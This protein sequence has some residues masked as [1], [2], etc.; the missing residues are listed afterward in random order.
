MKRFLTM[1]CLLLLMLLSGCKQAPEQC[2][3]KPVLYLYPETKTEVSVKLSYEG[4]LTCTY[5]AYQGGWKVAAF[6]NGRILDGNGRE[7]NYLYWEGKNR[8]EYDFSKGFCVE[9]KETAAFLED[10]LQKLGL[11]RKEANEFI[12]YWL[13]QMEQNPFNLISFQTKSYTENAQL[14]IDPCP[15]TLIRVFMAWKPL[16]EPVEIPPQE[17][18]APA[19]SGFTAVEWGGCKVNE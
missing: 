2:D 6:P 9:G 8:L 11:E 17:L 12:V 5:P 4:E 10:A 19:R 15:D 16:E 14:S 3:A 7:Y 1:G 13:P 18:S